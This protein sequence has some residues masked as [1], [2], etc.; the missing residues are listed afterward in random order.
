MHPSSR[1]D[2]V[3]VDPPSQ[4]YARTS[5]CCAVAAQTHDFDAAARTWK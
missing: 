5:A 3:L 1:I 2:V 4:G